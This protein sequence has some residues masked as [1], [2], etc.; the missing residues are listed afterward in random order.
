MGKIQTSDGIKPGH[1]HSADQV[2]VR[3]LL[4][5]AESRRRN[6]PR[7]PVFAK[8]RGSPILTRVCTKATVREVGR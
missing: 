8:W 4:R 7:K 3:I 2:N 5:M 6:R 1:K